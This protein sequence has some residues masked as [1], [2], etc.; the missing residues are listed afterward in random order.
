[1]KF[2]LRLNNDLPIA[3]YIAL[4]QAAERLGFAQFWVSHDL[5]LRSSW[6]I[7]SAVA[8][9][10]SRIEIGTCIVNPYTMNL[11]EIAMQAATLDELSQGR[12]NLGLGAGAG[13]FLSWVGIA[14]TQPLATMRES[15]RV[16]RRLWN[17]ERVA[18]NGAFVKGWTPEAYLRAPQTPIRRIP[19]YLGAM[20]AKML[21]LLGELADGG[22]PL[23]FPPEHFAN[24]KPLIAQGI[25]RAGRTAAEV[26]VAA[27]V[28][29]SIANDREA[30]RDAL[31]EKIAYYG[32]TLSPLILQ[33]LGLTTHD[34]APL[35]QAVIVEG[36]LSK[37]KQQVTAAMLRIGIMGT[38]TDV[39]QR[40]EGLAK[41][42]A[43]HLS[44]GPPLG[45][46]PL[47]ALEVLGTEVIP[48]FRT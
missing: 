39:I 47:A 33:Q 38:A 9:A 8:Q 43:N 10:T 26:D 15:M 14:Q 21:L 32:H 6:V 16:L 34:F 40:C 41:L 22:L 45:P 3:H 24:V 44:F 27:C 25:A 46:D 20:S 35:R 12:F 30:A 29:C 7:L 2:S 23:L 31:A 37:G 18:V 48:H 28:W 11:A 42:G 36:N 5:F 1:M 17:G 13:D 4:A 19:I